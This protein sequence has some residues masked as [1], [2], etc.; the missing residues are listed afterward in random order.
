[1][2]VTM[3]DTT[4]DGD[5]YVLA[6]NKKQAKKAHTDHEEHKELVTLTTTS[7]RITFKSP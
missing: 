2:Q 4:S 1:M 3:T 7:I 5:T 6:S